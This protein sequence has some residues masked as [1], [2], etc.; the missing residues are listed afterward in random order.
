LSKRKTKFIF[1]WRAFPVYDWIFPRVD[2][3][4]TTRG[5]LPRMLQTW[6]HSEIHPS[7]LFPVVVTKRPPRRSRLQTRKKKLSFFL[8]PF[9][10]SANIKFLAHST[11]QVSNDPHTHTQNDKKG[12]R[13]EGIFLKEDR[14]TSHNFVIEEIR[15]KSQWRRR[16]F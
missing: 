10:L 1:E 2:S 16:F 5:A 9:Y 13:N 6:I 4:R 7:N 3:L 11:L 8:F 12:K 14:V 15:L